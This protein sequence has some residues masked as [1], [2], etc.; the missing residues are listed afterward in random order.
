MMAIVEREPTPILYVSVSGPPD[1]AAKP[2]FERLEG[3]LG[4]LAGRRFY[5]YFDPAGPR[6]V[7]CVERREGDDP[8]ALGLEA[9]E[10]PGGTYLRVRL[11]DDPPALY[12]RIGPTF[13]ALAREAG[14]A[15]DRS[16]P[17]LE[18]YRSE[19]EVDVLVPVT[20]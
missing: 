14:D 20:E 8:A 15:A 16:R 13:D 5:G 19:N 2:A 10:L 11:K 12:G 3:A 17:W 6:Y 1:E 18:H 4:E 7:A 9:D